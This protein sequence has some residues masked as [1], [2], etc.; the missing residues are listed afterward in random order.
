MNI[1]LLL[2]P[3]MMSH[4]I[5]N[6]SQTDLHCTLKAPLWPLPA[7]LLHPLPGCSSLRHL[8][9]ATIYLLPILWPHQVPCCLRI[10]V[11]AVPSC[12]KYLLVTWRTS[13]PP[14]GLG[15]DVTCSQKLS[16]T[17]WWV[18][19]GHLYKIC[20][21]SSCPNLGGGVY[22]SWPWM[23]A[24]PVIAV[25]NQM[26]WKWCCAHSGPCLGVSTILVLAI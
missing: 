25:T 20:V 5:S 21:T 24:S 9:A 26:L 7:C 3:L 14:S 12:Q 19:D 6:E 11:H 8:T 23:R 18:K 17:T 4:C 2:N 16:L 13:F 10:F 1:H 22:F 15:S